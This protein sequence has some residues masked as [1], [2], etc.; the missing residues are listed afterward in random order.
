MFGERKHHSDQTEEEIEFWRMKKLSVHYIYSQEPNEIAPFTFNRLRVLKLKQMT[1]LSKEWVNFII[2]NDGLEKLTI[3]IN[4]NYEEKNGEESISCSQI[5]KEQL[6]KIV[7]WL[8]KL[9]QLRVT[10]AAVD[11][12]DIMA[13]LPK[14]KS[15]MIICLRDYC[16]VD[17]IVDTFDKLTA[18]K[19]WLV[20]YNA[21]DLILKR[22]GI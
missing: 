18:K 17:S 22:F 16:D 8:T 3:D 14:R 19:K 10:A 2:R 7:K 9:K 5:Q 13:I 6:L 4:C 15:L 1:T 21:K 11:A 12:K 20:D